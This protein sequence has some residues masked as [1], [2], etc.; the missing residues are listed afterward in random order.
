[1]ILCPRRTPTQIFSGHDEISYDDGV[2]KCVGFLVAVLKCICVNN[3]VICSISRFH[4]F[5]SGMPFAIKTK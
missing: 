5:P 4:F 1:M 2:I 3:F